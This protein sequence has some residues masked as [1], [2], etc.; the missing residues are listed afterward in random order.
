[1]PK[2]QK[3]ENIDWEKLAVPELKEK[4]L[5]EVK[6]KF[7]ILSLEADEQGQPA[8]EIMWKN[9]KESIEHGN[10]TAPKIEKKKSKAWMTDE[11][12]EK[13]EA[14]KKA[15]NTLAYEPLN[16]EIKKLCKNAKEEWF[17]TKC[18]EIE[19]HIN[20]NGTKKMHNCIKELTGSTRNN[21]TMG[22]IKDK[23]GNMLFENGKVLDRWAEYVGELFADTRPDLP[24]PS[25]DRGPP[26]MKS[27]V[28]KAIRITQ[29]GKAPG[30]DGITTEMLKLLED[31]GTDK[32]SE[33]FN[34]IYLNRHIS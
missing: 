2:S 13:M 19:S 4:Y 14:R 15:K 7:E 22:C 34:E 25:N 9:L 31:F 6:N 27:E 3:K 20:V 16:K 18:E 21:S 11:I 30:D 32:L 10:L 28:E 1:M 24:E 12:M 33:L 8:S 29:L 17:N 5:L 23:D 26:I